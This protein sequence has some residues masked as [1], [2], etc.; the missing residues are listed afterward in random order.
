MSSFF[1]KL[2]QKHLNIA[3]AL[4]EFGADANAR[5]KDSQCLL[6]LTSEQGYLN[7]AQLLLNW[8]VDPN[9]RGRGNQTALHLALGNAPQYVFCFFDDH[10]GANSG[11][12]VSCVHCLP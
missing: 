6:H 5:D 2:E 12:A 3:E 10:I 11:Q 9:I 7:G 4:L 8:G 1:S